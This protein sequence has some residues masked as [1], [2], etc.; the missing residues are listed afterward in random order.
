MTYIVDCINTY[1]C[2]FLDEVGAHDIQIATL[3]AAN[4]PVETEN[5]GGNLYCNCAA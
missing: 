4:G 1:K 2:S 5:I 3:E